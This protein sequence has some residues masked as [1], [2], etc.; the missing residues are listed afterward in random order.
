MPWRSAAPRLGFRLPVPPH[1]APPVEPPVPS[2]L[3]PEPAPAVPAADRFR[4]SSEHAK[5]RS[6][7][8]RLL[9]R[10]SSMWT[11][12]ALIGVIAIV[13]GIATYY[14]RAYGR[15]AV[16]QMVYHAWWFQGLWLLI[17]INI[18]GAAAVRF[19][20]RRR[21]LGFVVV[22]AGLL[23]L[24]AGFWVSAYRLDGIL[25]VPTGGSASQIRLDRDRLTVVEHEGADARRIG[26]SF[27]ALSLTD[28]P[29]LLRFSLDPVWPLPPPQMRRGDPL[30]VLLS[31]ASSDRWRYGA[32]LVPDGFPHIAVTGVVRWGSEQLTIGPGVAGDPPAVELTLRVRTPG[33]EEMA[34]DPVILTESGTREHD[35][36]PAQVTLARTRSQLLAADLL[37]PVTDLPEVPTLVVYHRGQAHRVAVAETL[38]QEV[39]LSDHLAIVITSAVER[40]VFRG[41]S[42]DDEPEAALD[43]LLIV[44]VGEGPVT[45]RT[46]RMVPAFAFHP[47]SLSVLPAQVD[48]AELI[49]EHPVLRSGGAGQGI[50]AAIVLTPT[51]PVLTALSRTRGRLPGVRM[52]AN[53]DAQWPLVGG[54]GMPMQATATVTYLPQARPTPR[55]IL[56]AGKD[57]ERAT[58]WIE[59]EA[60]RGTAR[61]RAWIARSDANPDAGSARL[62]LDDGSNVLL[63][64]DPEVYDLVKEHG[65]SVRLER[66]IERRDPGGERVAGYESEIVVEPV[67]G[68]PLAQRVAMNEPVTYGGAT[69]YQSSFMPEFDAHGRPIPGR[70]ASSVF[71]AATDPGRVLKYFGSLVLVAGMVLMY[72]LNRRLRVTR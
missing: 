69:L 51:E 14:E 64:Y 3:T 39:T 33:A 57:A 31:S 40:P 42:L 13:I 16:A 4:T 61:G 47:A 5:G 35:I 72:L 70:Y 36:G 19:P 60:R 56:V 2:D 44:R 9:A 8:M 41:H 52:V 67:K 55:P 25:E 18:F 65:F 21:Q 50:N 43:P 6:P 34:L 37:R 66:F 23:T 53:T 68:D 32:L 49:Y 48:G 22:H 58:R 15:I 1:D 12:A 63:R 59:V 10:M 38:P 29:S 7:A 54:E 45:T 17:A 30:T 28:L 62:E 26:V 24:M 11:A 71:T 27:Q 46:W 20:W